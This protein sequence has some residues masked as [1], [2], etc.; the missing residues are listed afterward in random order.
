MKELIVVPTVPYSHSQLMRDTAALKNAFPSLIGEENAGVSV[1]GRA[2]PLIRLGTGKRNVFFC[3]AH[4]ARDYM[5]SAYLMYAVNAYA[6]A[7]ADGKRI[8]GCDM[9]RLLSSCCMYVMPMV[10][11]DG[12]ALVQGGIKAVQHP[13]RVA[14]MLHVRPCYE[15]WMANVN[16]VDLGRQYPALWDQKYTVIT[17]P[18]SELYNGEAPAT[19]PEVRA[20]IQACEKYSFL[21]ALSFYTKGETIEY[22]DTHTN[23]KIPDALSLAK[24]IASVTGYG[25]SPVADNPGVYAA[26]FEN[27]FR[28]EFTRPA[29]HIQLSPATGGA[30]PHSDRGFYTLVWD[31]TK[32]LCAQALSAVCEQKSIAVG[33]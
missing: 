11:P 20:V 32:A 21:A 7:A 24:R 15:L 10:N 4:H 28:Q 12:V 27:W 2:L 16:G 26:C 1:E 30:M 29:L 9:S 13:K 33:L 6:Q 18:A 23:R 8:G 25:I 17:Q 3:G 22:A 14:A 31:K 19:E 5:T